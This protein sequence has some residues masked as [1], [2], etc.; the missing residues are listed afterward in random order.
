[1]AMTEY[2][3]SSSLGP[4]EVQPVAMVGM[5]SSWFTAILAGATGPNAQDAALITNPTTQITPAS[6]RLFT[7]NGRATRA[8]LRLKYDDG[9]TAPTSPVVAM[10]GRTRTSAS[11][12]TT[13]ERLYTLG[14]AARAT[15]TIDLTNDVADGTYKYTSASLEDQTFD[16]NGCNEFAV[17]VETAFAGTGTV[18]TSEIECK[19]T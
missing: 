5:P 10:F 17:G 4:S 11:V 12:V 19:L 1:M 3:A 18:N 13:W 14:A 16:A 15:L 2:N 6:H 7:Y 9:V 8:A